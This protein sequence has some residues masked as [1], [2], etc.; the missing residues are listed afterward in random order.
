MRLLITFTLLPICFTAIG[1]TSLTKKE[2]WG[3]VDTMFTPY[4]I[5]K[6]LTFYPS[7]YIGTESVYTDSAGID[8]IIQNSLPKG[9]GYIDAAGKE[10]GYRIFW[11]RII[12]ESA[13]PIEITIKFPADSFA[14]LPSGSYFKVFLPPNTMTL[15]KEGLYSY[16][17]TGLLSF[18]DTGLHA[19][20]MLQRTINPNEAFQFYVGTLSHQPKDSKLIPSGRIQTELILKGQELFYR[21]KQLD[22]PLIP[23]G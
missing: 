6:T 2:S 19:P 13:A 5:K 4:P 9:G 23:C 14:I 22:F 3:R 15:D 11:T 10:F 7:T 21:I 17:A 18:L 8:V 20:T 16:G 1:Q 12:N